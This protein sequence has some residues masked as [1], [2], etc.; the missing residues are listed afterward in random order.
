MKP[1]TVVFM[2]VCGCGKSSVAELYAAYTGSQLVEADTF[3]PPA[4]IAKMS[5][6]QPLTDADRQQWLEALAARIAQGKAAGQSLSVTCSALKK[7]YR[8]LLRRGDD[9]MVFV[10]LTGTPELL[11]Q[12]MQSR[13]GHFMPPSL[14]ASQL[15]ILEAPQRPE[16]RCLTIDI[17]PSVAEICNQV[18]A[19]LATLP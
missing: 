7:S 2:G 6:G 3:H 18:I 8:N 14:L 9:Q 17:T 19:Q 13:Q 11:T 1:S 15:Q 4:N 5:A 10:H 16:E 12:R